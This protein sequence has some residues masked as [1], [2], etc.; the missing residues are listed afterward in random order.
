MTGRPATPGQIRAA[1]VLLG[2]TQKD[3]G[4]F[5]ALSLPTIKRAETERKVSISPKAIETICGAL[6]RLGVVFLPDGPDGGPGVKL[7]S[8]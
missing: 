1:R 5:T 8:E 3:L 4:L 2:V 7:R 6:E